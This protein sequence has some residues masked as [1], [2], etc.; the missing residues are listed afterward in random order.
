MNKATAHR[1]ASVLLLLALPFTGSAIVV[2]DLS[3]DNHA[4]AAAQATK[5]FAS[6]GFLDLAFHNL[7]QNK[8]TETKCTGTLIDPRTV[9]TSADCL[10]PLISGQDHVLLDPG[11]TFTT[12]DDL[13]SPL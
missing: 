3:S 6:V 7:T 1:V 9:L 5:A 10:A 2:H 12:G 11:S 13:W 8:I 4:I